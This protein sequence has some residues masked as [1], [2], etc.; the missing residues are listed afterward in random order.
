MTTKLYLILA[1]ATIAVK[2]NAQNVGIGTTTPKA[3]LHVADSNVVFSAANP[4]LTV[5]G[6]T[7]VSGAG[8]R[9]MWYSGKAAFRTGFIDGTQWDKNNVGFYSFASGYSTTANNLYSTAL[10]RN[11]LAS[12]T[13]STS[14]GYFT[15]ASGSNSTALGAYSQ[16]TGNE[17]TALN[18]NTIASGFAATA[19]GFATIAKGAGSVAMGNYTKSLSAN[20]LVIGSFNDTTNTN[21]LFEVGNG[22]G[23]N[24][25]NN[26]MTI[27][28]NGDVGIGKS[29]PTSTLD[30]NGSISAK[31]ITNLESFAT[32]AVNALPIGN[33]YYVTLAPGVYDAYYQIPAA[34][35]CP[36]RMMIIRKMDGCCAFNARLVSPGSFFNYLGKVNDELFSEIKLGSFWNGVDP[37]AVQLISDGTNWIRY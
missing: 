29:T 6:N 9:M 18:S 7:P 12:G 33:A 3:R 32:S 34:A 8:A 16:A 36:G 28:Q 24:A 4:L 23:D 2:S 10:G 19:M 5:P 17:A 14:L 30:V 22:T 35:S 27:L 26:A 13:S 31:V 11:T 37:T 20:S 21:R 15:I 1:F 25:R